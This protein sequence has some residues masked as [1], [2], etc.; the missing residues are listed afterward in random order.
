MTTR[1]EWI[2]DKNGF[3]IGEKTILT[4]RVRVVR[5]VNINDWLAEQ[6]EAALKELEADKKAGGKNQAAILHNAGNIGL[7]FKGKNFVMNGYKP[8]QKKARKQFVN[9]TKPGVFPAGM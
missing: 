1:K 6:C 7:G 9:M 8:V 4:R 3:C 2:Y 5:K